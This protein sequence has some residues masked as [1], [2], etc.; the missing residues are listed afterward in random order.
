MKQRRLMKWLPILLG[1]LLI[2]T[3]VGCSNGDSEES[4]A[5]ET[6][7]ATTTEAI[8][9]EEE[10]ATIDLSNAT[11]LTEGKLT[12]GMVIDYPPFEYYP[13]NGDTPIGVDVDII[14]AVAKQLGLT[15]E[16]KNVPWD[17]ALFTNMGSEYDVVCSAVTITDE[18]LKDMIFS[19]SYIDSYQ[20]V[21]V[22]KDSNISINGFE[23][24][25]GLKVAV[26]KDTVSDELMQDYINNETIQVE[27]TENEVATRCF[28]QLIAGEIDAIVCDSTVTEGQVARNVDTLMEAYRDESKVEKF[29][30]A[31]EKNNIG[32][33]TAINEALNDLRNQNLDQTIID[34]WFSR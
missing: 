4:V 11:L 19:D 27:L 9:T 14:D 30:I 22:R 10:V 13:S 24:L 1:I 2:A 18:R 6:T 8:S 32:L 23:D 17:D 5:E 26:Q 34:N 3:F 25:D 21:V 33:Q 12:V 28:E 29:A 15:V 7:E 16:I 20:S 31:I